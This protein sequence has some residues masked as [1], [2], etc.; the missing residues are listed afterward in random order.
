MEGGKPYQAFYTLTGFP[1]DCV[2][3]KGVDEDSLWERIREA[4][5]R[6]LP[7]VASVNSVVL[8]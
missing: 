3:H 7:M 6:D 8:N 5:A 1:S 2:M 4:A